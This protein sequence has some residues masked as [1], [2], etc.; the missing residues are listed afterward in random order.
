MMTEVKKNSVETII[1][2]LTLSYFIMLPTNNLKKFKLLSL[3][4]PS[5]IKYIMRQKNI[6]VLDYQPRHVLRSEIASSYF[7]LNILPIVGIL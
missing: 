5:Q 7:G 1:G 4:L 3:S 2:K 6:S